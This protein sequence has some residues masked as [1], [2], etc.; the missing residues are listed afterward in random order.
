[1]K[2]RDDQTFMSLYFEPNTVEIATGDAGSFISAESWQRNTKQLGQVSTPELIAEL[3]AKWVMSVKPA[4]VLDPAAGLGGLT[5]RQQNLFHCRRIEFKPAALW[6]NVG[7]MPSKFSNFVFCLELRL[8]NG[9]PDFCSAG[10][11]NHDR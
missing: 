3:M 1:M 4:A 10:D 6:N 7:I 2:L 8:G 11:R 9:F 5:S